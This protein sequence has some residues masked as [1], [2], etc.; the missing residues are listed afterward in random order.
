MTRFLDVLFNINDTDNPELH[1]FYDTER[2]LFGS[3]N[4]VR[5]FNNRTCRCNNIRYH[6]DDDNDD[7]GD[8]EVG[9]VHDTIVSPDTSCDDCAIAPSDS[10]EC[11]ICYDSTEQPL[12]PL[13]SCSHSFHKHCI[14]RW[15]LR[16]NT[17]PLCRKN[18]CRTC[19][20]LYP[21][22]YRI[23]EEQQRILII[24]LKWRGS[25][26]ELRLDNS[27][28]DNFII[29]LYEI[30]EE[31]LREARDNQ[32]TTFYAPSYNILRIMSDMG[33]LAYSN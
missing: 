1:T 6:D 12:V 17:C 24:Y 33:A 14:D 19:T 18:I 31:T 15:V 3:I 21:A 13:N 26:Y 23:S 5:N 22:S 25:P 9:A 30:T 10:P 4:A 7:D 11:A 20:C 28:L 29:D 27:A 2:H 32:V 16:S 8:E